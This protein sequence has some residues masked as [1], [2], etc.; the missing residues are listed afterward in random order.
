MKA[1]VS[2]IY[3]A[4]DSQHWQ[5]LAKAKRDSIINSIPP[6]WRLASIPS[7]EEQSDVTG[8][9]ICRTLSTEEIE[10]TEADA[11]EILSYIST[12]QWKA[13][14]VIKA[15]SHRASIAHQLVPCLN[16]FLS[17]M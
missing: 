2:P 1:L 16:A 9:F 8:D 10:I 13:E 7:A 12:G 3:M 17:I 15:F 6:E 5:A 14:T 4:S 11:T